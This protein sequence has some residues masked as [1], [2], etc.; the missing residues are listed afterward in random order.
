MAADGSSDPQLSRFED[1]ME[2]IRGTVTIHGDIVSRD[3]E[4]WDCERE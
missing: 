1:L 3:P 4:L 2:R